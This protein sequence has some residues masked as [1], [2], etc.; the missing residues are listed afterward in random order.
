MKT[1]QVCLTLAAVMTGAAGAPSNIVPPPDM[2]W[3]GLENQDPPPPPP[4]PHHA[5]HAHTQ[6]KR[7]AK[8][9]SSDPKL[10][11]EFREFLE[12]KKTHP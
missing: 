12:W 9:A 11:E 4:R 5:V 8:E 3:S 2:E 7:A 6:P 10:Y 1:A